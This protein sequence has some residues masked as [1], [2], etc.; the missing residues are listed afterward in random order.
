MRNLNDRAQEMENYMKLFR[1]SDLSRLGRVENKLEGISSKILI[2]G[3]RMTE[4]EA[5]SLQTQ[6]KAQI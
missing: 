4:L 2:V 1:E 6:E 5:I 3:K